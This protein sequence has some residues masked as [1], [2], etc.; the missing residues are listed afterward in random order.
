MY[1][2]NMTTILE[3][4]FAIAI[5]I[6]I[7]I[8]HKILEWTYLNFLE[9]IRKNMISIL[10][11]S[12]KLAFISMA[13]V[14]HKIVDAVKEAWQEVKQ[15][16]LKMTVQFE[17]ITSSAIWKK[18]SISIIF[19]KFEANQPVFVKREIEED[20]DWDNLPPEVREAWLK[21]SQHNYKID[22]MEIREKELEA[23]TEAM[24]MEQ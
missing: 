20:L 6:A 23:M 22:V 5:T 2:E 10:E 15:F 13:K 4:V 14:N 12:V 16:L 21:D 11:S 19:K 1:Q 7:V 8:W 3:K 24:V 17:N 18:K 9:W